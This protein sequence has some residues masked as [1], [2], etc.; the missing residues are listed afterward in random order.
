M[1]NISPNE[2]IYFEKED[3]EPPMSNGKHQ[4][5][6]SIRRY[7]NV[8]AQNECEVFSILSFYFFLVCVKRFCVRVIGN[9][10]DQNPYIHRERRASSKGINVL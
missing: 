6:R 10:S 9:M 8:Y 4:C 3:L 1:K 2:L 5:Y 7:S